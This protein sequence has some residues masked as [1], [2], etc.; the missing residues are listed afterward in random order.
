MA[1]IYAYENFPFPVVEESRRLGHDLL[2]S[3]ESGNAGRAVP[4]PE[5]LAFAVSHQRVLV[6]LNRR[7][8]IGLHG[9]NSSHF[10]IIVCTFDPAFEAFG[11]RIHD[12]LSPEP[13]MVGKLVR[14]NRPG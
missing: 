4:D 1:R 9:G 3:L 5:V 6:T 13:N 8:F 2:T 14:V 10:G 12:A 7:H 11:R